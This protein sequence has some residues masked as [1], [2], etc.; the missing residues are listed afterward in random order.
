MSSNSSNNK[1]VFVVGGRTGGPL[2]PAMAIANMLNDFN[3]IIIGI[4]KGFEVTFAKSENIPIYFLPEAKLTLAS[5]SKLNIKEL[6]KELIATFLMFFK[7]IQSLFISIYYILKFRPVAII[8]SGS[9]LGVPLGFAS[10]ITNFLKLT[11][12]KLIVHQQDSKIS[13]SNKLIAKIADKVTVTFQSSVKDFGKVSCEVIPNSIDPKRFEINELQI[14]PKL[15]EFVSNK[16][17]PL[18]LIFGGGSGALAINSWV[19]DNIKV[20]LQK[21]KVLHLTG[22]LQQQ[23]TNLLD[24]KD[25]MVLKS[26]NKEMPMVLKNS[27]LVICRAGMS[28]ITEL[29]YL[30]KKAFLI[31]IPNS[32]QLDNAKAV[33]R[34]FPTLNQKSTI[35]NPQKEDWLEVI[36]TLYP[37]FFEQVVY[38]DNV[39]VQNQITNY[40]SSIKELIENS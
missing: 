19:Y 17:K 35:S 10:Y 3:P 4:E 11:N 34:F 18:L 37:S 16:E 6:L 1:S 25:Y 31:P 14:D 27:D 13:L 5:F 23:E 7:L 21:F 32:H 33:S 40:I 28:S 12:C 24:N 26:L 30:Q 36:D 15:N 29:R 20:I 38:Q 2:L 39:E 9:F 22:V 8:T